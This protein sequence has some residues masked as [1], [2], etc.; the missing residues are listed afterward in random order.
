MTDAINPQH[1]K[2]YRVEV[3]DILEDAVA[4]APDPV[5]GGYQWQVLKYALRMWDK[6]SPVDDVGKLIWY[7]KRLEAILKDRDNG[8]WSGEDIEPAY[9]PSSGSVNIPDRF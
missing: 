8:K 7:A 4:R 3:I 6:E 9:L 2:N 5:T 1:Y